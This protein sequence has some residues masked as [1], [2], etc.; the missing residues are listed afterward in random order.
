VLLTLALILI[1]DVRCK[2]KF[3]IELIVLAF[4]GRPIVVFVGVGTWRLATPGMDC[5]PPMAFTATAAT[6][7]QTSTLSRAK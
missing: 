2:I 4:S 5:V 6:V 1:T 7:I 3:E